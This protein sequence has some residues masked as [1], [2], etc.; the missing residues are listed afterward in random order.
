[1]KWLI[2]FLWLILGI[3]YYTGKSNFN[4]QCC[5]GINQTGSTEEKMDSTQGV[6]QPQRDP[7][8][9]QYN[10]DK[11]DTTDR[12]SAYR[13]SVIS[14]LKKGE[15]LVITGYYSENET[16]NTPYDNLG[17]ARA[18]A[19]KALFIQ[20]SGIA[21]ARVLTKGEIKEDAIQQ[22][23]LFKSHMFSTT[24]GDTNKNNVVTLKDR[25]LIYFEYG[26]D[27]TIEDEDILSYLDKVAKS[28]ST[29]GQKIYL[30]GHTDSQS[31]RGYNYR[32]GLKRAQKIADYLKSKGVSSQQIVV[33]SKGEDAPIAPNS[34][35]KGRQKNRRVELEIK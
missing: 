6:G 33:R 25:T 7:L 1:M 35:E 5:P 24:P 3:V 14:S 13:A 26:T 9:F 34:S 28:V 29:T 12:F 11:A 27:K 15:N 2:L 30:T 20:Q 31:G 21:P 17:I 16:N 4:K 19:I 23:G 18:E 10:S 22:S 32:L 8:L